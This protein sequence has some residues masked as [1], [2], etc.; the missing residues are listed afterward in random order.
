MHQDARVPFPISAKSGGVSG[1]PSPSWDHAKSNPSSHRLLPLRRL[2]PETEFTNTFA[3]VSF[4]E[5]M[6]QGLTMWLSLAEKPLH[7][8]GWIWAHDPPASTFWLPGSQVCHTIHTPS[9]SAH[10]RDVCHCP[11]HRLLI[12]TTM[13]TL[14]KQNPD[15]P[16]FHDSNRSPL[17]PHLFYL[18]KYW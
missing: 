7:S 14:R 6:R 12:S 4:W 2:V 8:P 16:A 10:S 5:A 9:S 17:F 13:K 11:R 15:K 3:C 1:V 18:A